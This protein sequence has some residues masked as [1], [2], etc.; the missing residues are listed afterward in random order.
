MWKKELLAALMTSPTALMLFK[1]KQRNVKHYDQFINRIWPYKVS[2]HIR[3]DYIDLPKTKLI[4]RLIKDLKRIDEIELKEIIRTS[5]SIKI[6]C[7]LGGSGSLFNIVKNMKT[8]QKAPSWSVASLIIGRL[9][10]RRGFFSTCTNDQIVYS[11][12]ISMFCYYCKEMQ[13]ERRTMS[14]CGSDIKDIKKWLKSRDN[15]VA[16]LEEL[17]SLIKK[18]QNKKK[19]IPYKSY[20]N[21]GI[22]IEYDGIKVPNRI[23]NQILNNGCVDFDSGFDGNCEERLRENRIRLNG[24]DG[25]KGLW[26]LLEHMKKCDKLAPNSSVHMHIDCLELNI[27]Q[28]DM[29][30]YALLGQMRS[31][32]INL[33]IDNNKILQEI[34]SLPYAYNFNDWS[35]D[36]IKA[37]DDFTTIEFR[38][39]I[40][41]LNYTDYVLQMLTLIH[42]I[43]CARYQIAVNT[44]YLNLLKELK[45]DFNK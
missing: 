19:T 26:I 10:D 43:S 34:F 45:M 25:L 18:Y 12:N 41:T 44:Q 38:F 2:K 11:N 31:R 36:R 39:C 37:H 3:K 23:A 5:T 22:E 20:L 33:F 9:N 8:M 14:I 40:V 1:K 24:I 35:C 4:E 42:I 27:G 29:K 32:V 21:V 17:L 28:H 7:N 30:K 13:N 16:Q 15:F 6:K